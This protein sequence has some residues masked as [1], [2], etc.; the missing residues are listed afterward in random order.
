MGSLRAE[1]R[2]YRR[3]FTL[4]R[5]P[6]RAETLMTRIADCCSVIR[7]RGDNV[8]AQKSRRIQ[9]TLY[10]EEARRGC[11]VAVLLPLFVLITSSTRLY[12]QD[13][14]RLIPNSNLSPDLPVLLVQELP[15]CELGYGPCG[16][17]R[18]AEEGKKTMELP[19]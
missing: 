7:D 14:P 4:G 9:G 6:T 11:S 13:G 8:P 17:R 15:Y 19:C 3:T 10:R 1:N 18:S 2:F 5:K 16:G 12:S